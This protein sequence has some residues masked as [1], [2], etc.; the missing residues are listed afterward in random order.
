M[1]GNTFGLYNCGGWRIFE[2]CR[3]FFW[4]HQ[5]Q[6]GNFQGNVIRFQQEAWTPP[7][8]MAGRGDMS[9]EQLHVIRT[10]EHKLSIS[11]DLY[12]IADRATIPIRP[13]K[14]IP[15]SGA[16]FEPLPPPLSLVLFPHSAHNL[17]RRYLA[18]L[19]TIALGQLLATVMGF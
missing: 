2:S 14:F 3:V 19:L 12:P 16:S 8:Q 4:R 13:L 7:R 17:L 9:R 5:L 18:L 11:C 10:S 6:L 1:N 15:H